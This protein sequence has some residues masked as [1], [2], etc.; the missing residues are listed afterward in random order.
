M[1]AGLSCETLVDNP[2]DLWVMVQESG[3]R[4]QGSGIRDQGS[5]VRVQGSGCRVQ[6]SGFRFQGAGFRLRVQGS[7]R[8]VYSIEYAEPDL[9][10]F[11]GCAQGNGHVAPNIQGYRSSVAF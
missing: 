1:P 4:V 10:P 8:R 11:L 5:G 6:G 2:P 7:G 3:I 9:D